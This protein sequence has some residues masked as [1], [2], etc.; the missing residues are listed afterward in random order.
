MGCKGSNSP[1]VEGDLA[2]RC[3]AAKYSRREIPRVGLRNPEAAPLAC[4]LDP[5]AIAE[6]DDYT[7][8]RC[9]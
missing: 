1:R 5:A 6:K 3:W 7:A 8:A 4:R 2:Q 9:K